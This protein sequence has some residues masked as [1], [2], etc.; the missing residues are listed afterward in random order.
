M[1]HDRRQ[2]RILAM[3][4]LCQWDVQH[5]HSDAA[6]LDCLAD[7]DASPQA[8]THAMRLVRAYWND[9]KSVDERIAHA[10]EH[11]EFDRISAVDRNAMRVAVVE[12]L[13]GTTPPA[14]VL[15]EAIEIAREFGGEESPLFVNGV[16]NSVL[17]TLR[18]ATGTGE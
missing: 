13:L 15:D 8:A 5:D 4:A 3:Q 10:A 2:A 17:T 1:P 7:L 16:L 9:A 12:L 18:S 11:W 14:V 6:L